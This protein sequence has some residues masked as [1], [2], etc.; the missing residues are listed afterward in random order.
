MNIIIIFI[1]VIAAFVILW[2]VLSKNKDTDNVVAYEC[3][4][5]GEHHCNCYQKDETK[6][7]GKV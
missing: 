7:P 2:K 6:P 4:Q 5:C 1:A 3:P